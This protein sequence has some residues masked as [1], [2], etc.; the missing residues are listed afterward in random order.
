MRHK[1]P[2]FNGL[3]PPTF[4][5]FAEV[6]RRRAYHNLLEVVRNIRWEI[7]DSVSHYIG[8]TQAIVGV[9]YD[10]GHPDAYQLQCRLNQMRDL[11]YARGMGS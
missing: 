6:T 7:P 2:N 11:A 4:E 9:M 8:A 3:A 5:T 10:M 1:E